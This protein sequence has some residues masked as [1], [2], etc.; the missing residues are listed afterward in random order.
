MVNLIIIGFGNVGRGLA[1]ILMLHRRMLKDRYGLDLKV[2]AIVDRGG[3]AISEAGVDL[4]KALEVKRGLGSVSAMKSIGKPG[5]SA[6]EVIEKINGDIVIEATSNNL[7]NGEPGLTHIRRALTSGKHVVTTNKGPLALALPSLLDLAQRKGVILRFSGAVSGAIPILDF[8]SN[9]LYGDDILSIQGVLNGTTNYILW[10]MSE[11][12]LTMD[13]AV[14]EAQRLGYAEKNISYD[15]DGLDTASKIV[16]IANYVLGLRVSL[17]EINIKGIRGITPEDLLE[18]KRRG[19]TIRLVGFISHDEVKVSPEE[20]SL[21]DPLSVGS[22]LNA[23]K[24]NCAYS[25]QHVVIGPGAGGRETASSVMRDIITIINDVCRKENSG[26]SPLKNYS[27]RAFLS[28]PRL[29]R[30]GGG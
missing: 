2:V 7:E 12:H 6:I 1:E 14:A 21:D 28:T 19:F 24:V 22:N 16:I 11:R 3:A 20:V 27:Y 10:S 29:T 23:V 30:I 4:T 26:R 15:I 25:G 8:A 9:L 17:K 18:A 13:Q 5:L